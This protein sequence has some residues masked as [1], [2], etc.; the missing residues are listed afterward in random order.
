[1]GQRKISL[2]A[3]SG[4]QVPYDR[5]GTVFGEWKGPVQTAMEAWHL[6]AM[7][8]QFSQVHPFSSRADTHPRWHTWRP[9]PCLCRSRKSSE[10]TSCSMMWLPVRSCACVQVCPTCLPASG[11][12]KR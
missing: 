4:L 3:M 10:G 5:N 8:F 9:Q 12:V 2:V 1:M 7:D 11:L 6:A